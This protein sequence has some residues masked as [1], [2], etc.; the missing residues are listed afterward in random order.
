MQLQRKPRDDLFAIY[1]LGYIYKGM[2][3][4]GI[5]P[6]KDNSS[7]LPNITELEK[8]IWE[9]GY[10]DALNSV[11]RSWS[12]IKQL[13]SDLDDEYNAKPITVKE[14]SCEN[15]KSSGA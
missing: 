2:E 7:Y 10:Q 12:E 11:Q 15:T 14:E 3:M 9:L 6:L 4:S 8:R 5:E 13:L 1:E